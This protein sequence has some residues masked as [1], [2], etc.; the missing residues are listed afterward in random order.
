MQQNFAQSLPEPTDFANQMITS[1]IN[2]HAT[3]IHLE[4]NHNQPRIRFRIKGKLI[5]FSYPPP[6]LFEALV[7][8]LKIRANLDIAEKRL[9]QDGRIFFTTTPQKAT[10]LRV[11]IVTTL[12]GEKVV[13]RVLG[14]AHTLIPLAQ[15]GMSSTQLAA[16]IQALAQS[17]G[18]IVLCGPT[19]SGKTTSLY[20]GLQHLNQEHNNIYTIEDPVEITLEGINQ[21]NVNP[22]IGLDFKRAL[23]ALLRQDPDIIMLGEIRDPETANIAVQAAQT[24]HLVLTTLHS[25]NPTRAILRLQQ[26]GINRFDLFESLQLIICQQLVTKNT[27]R[28]GLFETLTITDDIRKLYLKQ[29]HVWQIQKFTKTNYE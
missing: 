5:L 12:F 23:R 7:S 3:D 28:R 26:L 14:T 2:K 18:L 21:I 13:L 22:A 1:A 29:S 20:A 24:G 15:L 16:Y 9:P 17:Q 25:A 10:H 11:S 19:G 27:K 4:P 6:S 8:H